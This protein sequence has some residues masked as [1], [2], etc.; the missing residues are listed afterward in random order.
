MTAKKDET[1]DA[2]SEAIEK[3]KATDNV[4]TT[5]ETA[6]EE[7]VSTDAD[8]SDQEAKSE[9]KEE[10]TT[11]TSEEVVDGKADA[12]A[13]TS[14][15]TEK[16]EYLLIFRNERWDLPKGKLEVNEKLEDTA[17]REVEEECGVANLTL[18]AKLQTTFH[19][20]ELKGVRVLKD[21]HWYNMGCTG[22][23]TLKPQTNE[24]IEK[25]EWMNLAQIKE[26]R[27]N[28]YGTI[29]DILSGLH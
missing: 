14:K 19:T 5:A 10:A 1:T 26:A 6:V 12:P 3:E 11:N 15:D 25:A 17:L 7:K 22:S 4:K 24:G 13:E 27:A 2:S 23:S 20:Y 9:S 18:G 21:S 16:N 28:T 8:P 29:N